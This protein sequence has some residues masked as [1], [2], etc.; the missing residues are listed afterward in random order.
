MIYFFLGLIAGLLLAVICMLSVKRFQTPIERTLKQVENKVKE[1][2]E[3]FMEN[4]DVENFK[5]WMDN[6]PKV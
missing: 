6:L 4:E 1:K 3:I 2:G 5:N